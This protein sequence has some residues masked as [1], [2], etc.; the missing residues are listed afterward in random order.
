MAIIT[1]DIMSKYILVYIVHVLQ[2]GRTP[3]HRAARY[4]HNEAVKI[5][6]DLGA[7]IDIKNNVS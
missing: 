5:L 6:T 4:G 3:L 7:T 1:C 2:D